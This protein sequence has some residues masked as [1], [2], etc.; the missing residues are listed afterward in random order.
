MLGVEMD[1][2]AGYLEL[3]VD[4]RIGKEDFEKAVAAVDVL[5]ETHKKID[6]VEVVLDV[7]WVEPE[8]WWKDI[9][10]HLNHRHFLRHAAVVSDS[11]WVGPITRLFAGL[12]PAAIRTYSVG[13]IEEARR[14]AK[15][16]DPK[17]EDEFET[18]ANFA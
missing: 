9:V 1:T 13:E 11:G 8:V 3:T 16:G 10:F 7:G 2:K 6:V 5:L 14:W 12:Y 4:G 15:E 17:G 18:A